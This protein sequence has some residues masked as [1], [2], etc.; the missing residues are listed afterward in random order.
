MSTQLSD[1]MGMNA[2]NHTFAKRYN[3]AVGKRVADSK[4]L[5]KS[6]MRKAKISTPRLYRVFRKQEDLERF[7]FTKL[8][9]SFVVKPNRGLGGEG[10]IVVKEG[11]TYA[12]EWVTTQG[13]VISARDLKLHIEDIMEGRF[14]MKDLPDFAFVEERVRIHPAFSKYAYHGTPD[15]RVIMFNKIP[16]MAMLRLPT[17]ESGGRANLHQG[18]VGA[19]I[20][21]ASG[22][23][24]FAIQY[25]DEVVFMPGTKRKVRGIQIPEWDKVLETAIRAQEQVEL[26]YMGVDIVLQPSLKT[27]G[28]TII[29][30]LELNAQPGL[31]IQM[32]NKAGLLRRMERVE[33]LEVDMPEKGIRIAKELFGDKSLAHLG[34]RMKSIGVFEDVEVVDQLGE[35]HMVKAKVDTG[36][37]RTSIDRD[38][39]KKLG[40]LRKDNVLMEQKIGSALGEHKR[41]VIGIS[42]YL[43]GRRVETSASVADRSGLKRLMLIGR[44]D[45]QGFIIE[46]GG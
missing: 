44:R 26:G 31:K 46:F 37:W 4:L 3:R 36:A 21:M 14:S 10:I 2:R 23:T 5:T 18:A 20:D 9:E 30:I 27:P 32:A 11:G 45:L 34:K 1:F 38:L 39:A 24:T 28:K 33:G 41:K 19:G 29:K 7:D 43:A 22:V 6:A 25:S 15:I 40:L 42:Y 13:E 35:R 17:K 12:G 16:V 8:P